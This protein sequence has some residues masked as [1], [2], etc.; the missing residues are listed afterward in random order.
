MWRADGRE[1]CDAVGHSFVDDHVTCIKTTHTV[2]ND[3]NLLTSCSL[4]H[5]VDV[6]DQSL[7]PQI[8]RSRKREI[9]RR[10]CKPVC[11]QMIFDTFEI[12]ELI[13]VT[14]VRDFKPLPKD[15]CENVKPGYSM[16]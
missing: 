10:D 16:Y 8:N 9:R 14:I 1:G 7:S 13:A 2:G 6:I 5:I 15:H 4:Q 3:M 11:L 12:V